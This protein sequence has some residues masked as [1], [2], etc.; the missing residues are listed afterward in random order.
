MAVQELILH[1]CADPDA[2]VP[3]IVYPTLQ[4]EQSTVAV[5]HNVAPEPVAIVGVPLGQVQV[6]AVHVKVLKALFVPHVAVP[7][8]LY[9]VLHATVTV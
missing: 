8:P 4:T 9:P 3:D 7:P 5:S 1:V 2:A 6:L